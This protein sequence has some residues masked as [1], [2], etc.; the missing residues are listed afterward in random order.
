MSNAPDRLRVCDRLTDEELRA[1][2][3]RV[4]LPATRQDLRRGEDR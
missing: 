2:A 1:L 3:E 4:G